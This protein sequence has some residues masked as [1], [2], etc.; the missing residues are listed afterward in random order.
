M[1]IAY[2]TSGEFSFF[3]GAQAQLDE[4]INELQSE[5]YANNEHGE[6]EQ[7]INKSVQ[8]LLRRLL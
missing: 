6:I 8:E 3:S 2:V 1:N 4:L 5:D 7:Y